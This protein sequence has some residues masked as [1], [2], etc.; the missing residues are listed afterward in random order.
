MFGP[1]FHGCA[2]TIVLV[3]LDAGIRGVDGPPHI[4]VVLRDHGVAV[5]VNEVV[6]GGH[7]I[8]LLKMGKRA[9]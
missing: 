1:V 2:D 8:P 4:K 7:R 6:L 3:D 9:L 5:A